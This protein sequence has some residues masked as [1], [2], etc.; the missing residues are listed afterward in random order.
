M[1][2]ENLLDKVWGEVATGMDPVEAVYGIVPRFWD[3][4]IEIVQSDRMGV[5]SAQY[6]EMKK[7]GALYGSSLYS[8]L[9][10]VVEKFLLVRTIQLLE[11]QKMRLLGDHD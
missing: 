7:D 3:E 9:S 6:G 5:I 10:A 8:D 11:E 1:T 2:L 4:L